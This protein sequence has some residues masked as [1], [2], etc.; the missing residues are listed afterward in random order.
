MDK[1][2]Q[3]NTEYKKRCT[4][5]RLLTFISPKISNNCRL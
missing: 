3:K 4:P 5:A 2:K 1:S